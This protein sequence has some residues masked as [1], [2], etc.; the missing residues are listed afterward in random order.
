MKKISVVSPIFNEKEIIGL[1]LESLRNIL[2]KQSDYNYEIVL[3]NDGSIDSTFKKLLNFSRNNP[4]CIVVDL[5]KNF[6]HQVAVGAGLDYASGDIIIT[7][8]SDLQDPPEVLSKMVEKWEKGYKVVHGTRSSRKDGL[9]KD[10][11][12]KIYYKIMSFFSNG[13]IPE[14]TADFRLI[15]REVVDEINKNSGSK[16]FLRGFI[17]LLDIPQTSVFYIRPKRELGKSK[18][19][20][21]KMLK[22]AIEGIKLLIIFK[23]KK[24][25]PIEYEVAGIYRNGKKID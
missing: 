17:S 12:A 1:F 15:D 9:F 10:L 23:N 13:K 22:L 20:F 3:V 21:L 6:G 2:K 14:N 11:S 24:I 16:R 5:S 19:S 7:M 18:Y 25:Q 8:D 4:E